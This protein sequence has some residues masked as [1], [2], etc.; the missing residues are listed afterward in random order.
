MHHKL[1]HFYLTVVRSKLLENFNFNNPCKVPKLVKIVLSR[2]FDSSCQNSKIL[3]SLLNELSVLSGQKAIVTPAKK[4]ISNFKIRQGNPVG[5][6]VTLRGYKMYAFLERLI[7][8]ILPRVSDFQGLSKSG[9]SKSGNSYSFGFLDQSMFPEIDF[10]KIAKLEGLNLTIV[11]NTRSKEHS[12][13]LLRSL[14]MPIKFV[15]I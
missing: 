9:F 4:A 13:F 15:I 2:S 7:N 12:L 3:D 8:L 6:M 14:G 5:I 10:E 11:T 1:R